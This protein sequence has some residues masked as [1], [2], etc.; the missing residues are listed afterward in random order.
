MNTPIAQL[1]IHSPE[2]QLSKGN[3]IIR[4]KSKLANNTASYNR[5]GNIQ[6]FSEMNKGEKLILPAA[7]QSYGI[8]KKQNNNRKVSFK[9]C[10]KTVLGSYEI[11]SKINYRDA[12]SYSSTHSTNSA[13]SREYYKIYRDEPYF[14]DNSQSSRYFRKI[15]PESLSVSFGSKKNISGLSETIQVATIKEKLNVILD[16]LKIEKKEK[17]T[18]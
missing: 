2:K 18:E 10:L 11:P 8:E 1:T 16:L 14:E 9:A 3:S 12:K 6:C 7:F 5:K 13:K 15:K 4:V 17:K